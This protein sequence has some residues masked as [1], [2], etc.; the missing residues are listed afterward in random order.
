MVLLPSHDI[1]TANSGEVSL[2]SPSPHCYASVYHGTT[3][4]FGLEGTLKLTPSQPYC[5]QGH[6]PLPRLLTAPSSLALSASTLPAHVES[7]IHRHPQILLL[8]AALKPFS[9][10]PPS[11]LGIPP[12]SCR[13]LHLALFNSMRSAWAHL[14]ILP[15]A[16]WMASLP[17]ALSILH[18]FMAERSTRTKSSEDLL[19]FVAVFYTSPLQILFLRNSSESLCKKTTLQ[20]EQRQLHVALGFAQ[21]IPRGNHRKSPK[22]T[23]KETRK[24]HSG[25]LRRG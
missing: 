24:T 13:T 4:W 22:L 1:H 15:R 5:R 17:S 9:A 3:E 12:P 18:A 14:S 25:T 19:S 16:L 7:S 11:V 6:L 23:L 2:L 20:A 8:R 10:Q 21:P